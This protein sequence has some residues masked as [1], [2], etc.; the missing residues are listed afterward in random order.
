MEISKKEA[1][2]IAEAKQEIKEGKCQ[3]MSVDK[4]MKAIS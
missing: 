4:I 3:I 1:K 2:S